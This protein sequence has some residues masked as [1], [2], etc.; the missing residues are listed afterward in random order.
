MF[1]LLC[2]S[3]ACV[4]CPFNICFKVERVIAGKICLISSSPDKKG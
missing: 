4:A 1:Y 2:L 3:P